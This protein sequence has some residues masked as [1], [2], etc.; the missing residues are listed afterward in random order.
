M[1]I[2]ASVRTWVIIG[3]AILVGFL[4]WKVYDSGVQ[5]ERTKQELA[6][7]RQKQKNMQSGVVAADK[8]VKDSNK[9]EVQL[10]ERVKYV[11]TVPDVQCP[12]GPVDAAVDL[13]RDP[14][15]Q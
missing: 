2:L 13:L 5:H 6:D 10:R 11:Q 15:G 3:L 12:A 14:A 7:L 4:V 1:G 8:A 9:I